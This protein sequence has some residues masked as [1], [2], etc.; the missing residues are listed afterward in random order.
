MIANRTHQLKC[1]IRFFVTKLLLFHFKKSVCI[2]FNDPMLMLVYNNMAACALS[3]LGSLALN[4][5]QC[6]RPTGL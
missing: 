3:A 4:N 2:T 5:E 1:S 6:L